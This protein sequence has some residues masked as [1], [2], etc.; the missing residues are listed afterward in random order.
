VRAG[1]VYTHRVRKVKEGFEEEF[2]IGERQRKISTKLRADVENHAC[3]LTFWS[4]ASLPL[5]DEKFR[6]PQPDSVV[7]NNEAGCT[8]IV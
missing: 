2:L 8:L 7:L 3:S 5:A 4:Y 1:G 6:N